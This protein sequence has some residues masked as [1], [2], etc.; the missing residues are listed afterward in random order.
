MTGRVDAAPP[1]PRTLRAQ[2]VLFALSSPRHHLLRLFT[3]AHLCSSGR[4][5]QQPF[6]PRL[7]QIVVNRI[8]ILGSNSA[9]SPAIADLGPPTHSQLTCRAR[10]GRYELARVGVDTKSVQQQLDA[11]NEKIRS[12]EHKNSRLTD[13]SNVYE[14]ELRELQLKL[15]RLHPNPTA[16][17]LALVTLDPP[18]SLSEL[19]SDTRTGYGFGQSLGGGV[20]QL[21]FL[22]TGDGGD[23]S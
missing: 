15:V 12:L 13:Q 18:L 7:D 10:R 9:C 22:L 11:A 19:A 23:G 3:V 4:K 17:P 6:I 16:P 21:A 8:G 1:C 20:G 14:D 5:K 2:C